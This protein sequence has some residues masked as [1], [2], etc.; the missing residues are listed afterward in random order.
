MTVAT[1][2]WI[3]HEVCCI[4]GTGNEWQEIRGLSEG[5]TKEGNDEAEECVEPALP[6]T[7]AEIGA[8]YRASAQLLRERLAVLREAEKQTQDPEEAWHLHQ[9][10]A[11]LVPMLTQCND[12]ACICTHYYERGFRVDERYRI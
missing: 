7:L 4:I 2:R 1:F 5:T 10:I 12:L 11:M 3:S 6:M 8:E 9:R